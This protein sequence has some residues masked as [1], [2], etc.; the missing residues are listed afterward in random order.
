MLHW[1]YIGLM[2]LITIVIIVEI[3]AEKN[4]RRQLAFAIAVIPF[5]LAILHI[6]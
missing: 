4:W 2:S 6:K 1:I 3:F 5:I